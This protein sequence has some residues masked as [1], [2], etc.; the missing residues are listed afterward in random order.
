M[1]KNYNK[2]N[3]NTEKVLKKK[4]II[5]FKKENLIKKLNEQKSY[6]KKILENTD[7]LIKKSNEQKSYTEKI[8]QDTPLLKE[9]IP[10]KKHQLLKNSNKQTANK[11]K[12]TYTSLFEGM[13][14]K[15]KY[16]QLKNLK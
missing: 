11:K 14:T 4:K 13:N 10:L 9:I 3:T 6:T 16:S 7:K 8:L 2:Q 15:C 12:L 1:I 5:L